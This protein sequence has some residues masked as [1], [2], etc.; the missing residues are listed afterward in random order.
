MTEAIIALGGHS[1]PL[2]PFSGKGRYNFPVMKV[3]VVSPH[4]YPETFSTLHMICEGLVKR[5]HEVL[6]VTNQPNYGLDH[7]Q[8]GYEG[9]H[10]EIINGV[11]V[12]RCKVTPKK[13]GRIKNYL[14]FWKESKRYIRHIKKEYD[15]VYSQVMSPIISVVGANQYAKK[16]NVKH[17]HQCY[18]LWPESAVVTG[19]IKKNSLLYRFLYKWSRSIYAKMDFILI[20]SPSFE[21]YFRK[22]LKLIDIP[23]QYVPQQAV[24]G[25]QS[26]EDVIFDTPYSFVYAGN[27]GSLQLVENL[28]GAMALIKTEGVKLHLI[29]QGL[30][31][32][33]AKH[34][35]EE[36][37]LEDKV[38]LHG[39]LSRGVTASYFG[40]A[41]ALVVSLK[42]DGFV[43]AT[44]PNKLVSSLYYGKP[45]LGVIKGD[46][47]KV[48][49]E[50]GA[51]IFSN[52]ESEEEIAQAID[53]LLSLS[54]EERNRLGEN[55]KR[56]YEKKYDF[57][58]ILDEIE[59][60]LLN[61]I[62]EKK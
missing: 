10:D 37:S 50:A 11:R 13:K 53:N 7:I 52:G 14:G 18:D 41:T 16:H 57:N 56:Y 31:F 15:V 29:G 51:A 8:E 17:V 34:L 38:V 9:I 27:I 61:N 60:A 26:Q 22:E 55:G 6:V 58:A 5:G 62:K 32:E 45:I 25:E 21:D 28:I 19:A 33:A 36:K 47:A 2:F 23:I 4:Y 35:I 39:P 44:I 46:G 40:N 54:E 42:G 43:G 20:S 1:F 12:H 48:L 30:R 59:T 24:L 49:E 3:L